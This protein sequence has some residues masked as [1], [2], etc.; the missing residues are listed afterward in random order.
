MIKLTRLDGR[1]FLVNCDL[2]EFIEG[3]PDTVITLRTEKKILVKEPV[4]EVLKRIVTFKRSVF[5]NPFTQRG[6]KFIVNTDSPDL[7]FSNRDLKDM[8]NI[9]DIRE[10]EEYEE[11]EDKDEG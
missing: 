8:K 1:E 3:M 9:H 11:E 10:L 7:F 2:I 4:D 5:S 6:R